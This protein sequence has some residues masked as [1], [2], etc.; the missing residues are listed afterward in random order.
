MC[1]ESAVAPGAP[2]RYSSR[3]SRRTVKP[4]AQE[5]GTAIRL[6]PPHLLVP[7][8]VPERSEKAAQIC[9]HVPLGFLEAEDV[10]VERRDVTQDGRHPQLRSEKD[11]GNARVYVTG[12]VPR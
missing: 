6:A 4:P 1:P 7:A 10:G 12:A 8:G 11:C 3:R 5:G 9:E 2:A